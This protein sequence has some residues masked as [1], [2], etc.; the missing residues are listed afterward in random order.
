MLPF[1]A[2]FTWLKLL[3]KSLHRRCNSEVLGGLVPPAVFKIVGTGVNLRSGGFDSHALPPFSPW[4]SAASQELTLRLWGP[5]LVILR[6]YWALCGFFEGRCHA[7]SGV[8]SVTMEEHRRIH[9]MPL[10]VSEAKYGL[11]H[12]KPAA[13]ALP[14]TGWTTG[15]A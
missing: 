13:S 12:Y 6:M 10:T 2:G 9:S 7:P 3:L 1:A 5:W 11:R 14:L 8:M 15:L 4:W